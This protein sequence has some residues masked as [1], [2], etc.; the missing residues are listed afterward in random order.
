MSDTEIGGEKR[1]RGAEGG[2]EGGPGAF[3]R[4][5]RRREK[6]GE[7]TSRQNVSTGL[8]LRRV[9]ERQRGDWPK[10]AG[11]KMERRRK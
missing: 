9:S 11:V 4:G 3:Y 5:Q 8:D 2:R 10:D 6:R 7:A 1:E